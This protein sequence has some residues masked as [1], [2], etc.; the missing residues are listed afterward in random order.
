MI[1]TSKQNLMSQTVAEI[2]KL[3]VNLNLGTIADR[4]PDILADAEQKATAYSEFA[5]NLFK[6][7]LNSRME[8]R[9]S[10]ALK[11]SKLGIV[12]ELE[13][14]N[15]QLR[16]KLEA[17]VIKELCTCQF[18]AEKRNVLCLGGSGLGKTTIAKIIS[19]HACL[20]G[21]SVVFVNTAS[22]LDDLQGSFADNSFS[23]TLHRY[24]KPRLL[25]LDEFGY[26]NISH[27][28]A[29]CLFRLVS[30]RHK[31]GSIILTACTGF[32]NWKHFFP[33]ESSAMITIDRLVDRA[34]ILR[35]TGEGCRTPNEIYGESFE[36]NNNSNERQKD[37]ITQ[38]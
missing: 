30:A 13:S 18:I 6:T 28:G 14:F 7:E 1:Q 31:N 21:Y 4:L 34:T 29:Q 38:K 25:V 10:R 37:E 12:E 36:E 5:M 22:M 33:S 20:S 15:F 8:K 23:K 26:E 9:I 16:P 11:A 2:Q 17:R 24:V 35:F 32:K 3:A 27:Q 19:R